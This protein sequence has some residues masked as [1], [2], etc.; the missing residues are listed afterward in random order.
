MRANFVR[1]HRDEELSRGVTLLHKALSEH[2][3]ELEKVERSPGL[4]DALNVG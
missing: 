1:Y 2:V 4:D 3:K